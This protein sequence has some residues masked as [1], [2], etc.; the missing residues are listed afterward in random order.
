MPGRRA[1]ITL[2]LTGWLVGN[3]HL[4]QSGLEGGPSMGGDKM[5]PV[6]QTQSSL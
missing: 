3:R 4:D 5:V 6:S 1:P 2:V